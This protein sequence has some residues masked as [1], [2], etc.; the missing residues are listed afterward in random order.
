MLDIPSQNQGPYLKTLQFKPGVQTQ[1]LTLEAT[2]PLAALLGL[3]MVWAQGSNLEEIL[4]SGAA[5]PDRGARKEDK[6]ISV[7]SH[8][9]LIARSQ[10]LQI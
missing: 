5:I 2:G 8:G 9:S 4:F 1:A 3:R 7:Y 6:E 10:T